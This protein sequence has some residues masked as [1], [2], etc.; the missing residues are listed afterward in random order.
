M[1][2]GTIERPAAFSELVVIRKDFARWLAHHSIHGSPADQLL[3]IL[4]EVVT[5]AIEASPENATITTQ[6]ALDDVEVRLTVED[7]GPGFRYHRA[8]PVGPEA[9]RGRGLT[10]VEALSD[11][12][13]VQNDGNRTTVT[14]WTRVKR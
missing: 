10:I 7:D 13:Q 1:A 3:V 9:V 14:T 12:I 4:N 5:N 6:W 11:R 2:D 8:E